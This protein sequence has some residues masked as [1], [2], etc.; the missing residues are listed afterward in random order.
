MNKE[1]QQEQNNVLNN[2]MGVLKDVLMD[3]G[4]ELDATTMEI[5]RLKV[6][7][8]RTQQHIDEMQKKFNFIKAK[9]ETKIFA[10]LP[11]ASAANPDT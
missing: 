9:T 7:D 11:D 10:A 4:S 8:Q 3:F 1:L 2:N 5:N 6:N